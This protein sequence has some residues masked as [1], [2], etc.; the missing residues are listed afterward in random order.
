LLRDPAIESE[1]FRRDL[2]THHFREISALEVSSF[3]VIA[4]YKLTFT[5][6]LTMYPSFNYQRLN[7][8]GHR[9]P[10]VKHWCRTSCCCRR[11]LFL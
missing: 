3:Y 7:F 11:W 2:K 4:L 10:D 5:Y 9:F 1:H 8:S 6:L